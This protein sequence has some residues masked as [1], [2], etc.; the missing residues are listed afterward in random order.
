MF[1]LFLR[2]RSQNFLRRVG[3]SEFRV[4]STDRNVETDQHRVGAIMAAIEDAL[5]AAERER[6]GLGRRVDDV[7]ARAAVTLGNGDDEYLHREP[8]DSHHHDLFD[9]E[10][11][12]G[13]KRLRELVAA[14]AHFRFIKA[15]MQSRFPDYRPQSPREHQ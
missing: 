14:I 8:L 10:I 6:V 12:N 15:A 9:V 1:Q 7:M 2:A 11:V 13:Q 4:R 5:Q 3:V